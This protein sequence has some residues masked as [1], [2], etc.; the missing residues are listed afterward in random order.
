MKALSIAANNKYTETQLV[1]LGVWLLRN[2]GE[3]ERALETWLAI[4]D[5]NCTWIAFKPHFTLVQETLKNVR[6]P[7]V[8][9]A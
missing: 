1:N 8:R 2:M 5:A 3:F 7:T 6:G 4:P 9:N